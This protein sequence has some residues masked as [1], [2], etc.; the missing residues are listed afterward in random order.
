MRRLNKSKTR[1]RV[2]DQYSNS[3]IKKIEKN[4]K[5]WHE[6]EKILKRLGEIAKGRNVKIES[7]QLFPYYQVSRNSIDPIFNSGYRQRESQRINSENIALAKRL[8]MRRSEF[9]LKQFDSEYKK[10]LSYIHLIKKVK[11]RRYFVVYLDK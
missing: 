3:S 11:S 6:N 1:A 4:N 7:L 5:I 9:D 8:I 10:H 2:F